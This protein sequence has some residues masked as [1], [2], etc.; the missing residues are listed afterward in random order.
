MESKPGSKENA[1]GTCRDKHDLEGQKTCSYE[2]TPDCQICLL[3]FHGPADRRC[4]MESKLGLIK[5]A[6]Q[7]YCDG[8]HQEGIKVCSWEKTPGCQKFLKGEITETQLYAWAKEDLAEL[9][10]WNGESNGYPAHFTDAAKEQAKLDGA[11]VNCLRTVKNNGSHGV[12]EEDSLGEKVGV[13]NAVYRRACVDTGMSS[14]FFRHF[15]TWKEFV[16][17]KLAEDDFFEKA[18]EEIRKIAAGQNV[19]ESL[20]TGRSV[21]G[22]MDC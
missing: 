17:G 8:H 19:N 13:A 10:F 18:G 21:A 2:K 22:K 7:T 1:N 20:Q 15:A 11:F 16:H 14:C 6:N 5:K 4:A 12:S 9:K 3:Q